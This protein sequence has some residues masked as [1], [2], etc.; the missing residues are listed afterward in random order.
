M[1]SL[2]SM[3]PKLLS[4]ICIQSL[5]GVY[6]KFVELAMPNMGIRYSFRV[7]YISINS[8]ILVLKNLHSAV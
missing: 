5:S 4:L 2:P 3:L 1:L 6:K 7:L 8:V